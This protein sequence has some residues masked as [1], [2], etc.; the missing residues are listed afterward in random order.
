[1]LYITDKIDI[2]LTYEI[3]KKTK[4]FIDEETWKEKKRSE[5]NKNEM[6]REMINTVCLNCVRFKYFVFDSWF[7]N[8][9][10]INK[11]L[12][13]KKHFIS[14]L[15]KNRLISLSKED[16]IR[17]ISQNLESLK[18]NN[19]DIL[20]VYIKW[21]DKELI[22]CKQIFINK[23]WNN[24]ERYLLSSDTNL[25]F[26]SITMNYKKRWWIEESF[27]SMKSNTWFSKSPAHTIITQENHIFASIVAF[28]KL[29]V[30]SFSNMTNNFALKQ[31]IYISA[32]KAWY[33]ELQKLKQSYFLP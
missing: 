20:K 13:I 8:S 25:D 19:W 23:D 1:M 33:S 12:E 4:K 14:E 2:P 6:F 16:K 29:Q 3:V 10:N 17:W 28:F 24:W 30:I 5:K 18:M 27:K 26:E 22:L 9:K 7:C 32:L 11:I 21:V 15:P 31:K